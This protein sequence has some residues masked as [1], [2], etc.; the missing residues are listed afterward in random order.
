[1]N[2]QT[3]RL[4]EVLRA[5]LGING[6]MISGS[7]SGYRSAYPTHEVYFNANIFAQ[8]EGKVWYGDIDLTL[9]HHKLQ[10]VANI[11]GCKLFILREHDGR[12]EFEDLSETEFIKKAV[13]IIEPK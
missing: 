1:M 12:F 7:K 11:T 8:N 5:E 3:T 9:D 6:R 4:R 2:T 10:T 13:A